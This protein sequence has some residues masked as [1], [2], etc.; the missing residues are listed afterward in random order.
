[1]KTLKSI[2][3]QFLS[4]ILILGLT[5]N[6]AKAQQKPSPPAKASGIIDGVSVKIDYHSPGVKGRV[7]FGGLEEW[8]KVWRAGANNATTI[9]FSEDVKING[10]P[11]PKGKYSF[12]IIPKENDDWTII[13]NTVWD[14]WGAYKYDESKDALRVDVIPV[15]TEL[16]ERLKYTVNEDEGTVAMTWAKVSVPF[17]VSK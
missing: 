13:F 16:T 5:S 11:L 12:F 1:M 7:I 10:N 8:D 14:Q 17:T 2:T 4:V 9:E 6:L 15:D 3:T